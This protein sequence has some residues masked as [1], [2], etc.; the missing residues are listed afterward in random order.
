MRYGEPELFGT[1]D[2]KWVPEKYEYGNK[3]RCA[4]C[5]Y[6]AIRHWGENTTYYTP[7]GNYSWSPNVL[8]NGKPNSNYRPEQIEPACNR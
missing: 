5:A 3:W 4:K 6:T 7:E 1:S 2:H 8:V